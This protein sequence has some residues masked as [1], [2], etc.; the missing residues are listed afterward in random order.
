MVTGDRRGMIGCM[1]G[2]GIGAP[3]ARLDADAIERVCAQALDGWD[4]DGERVLVLVPD[5]TR[6]CPL[7]ELFGAVHRRLADRV[8]GI[9]VLIALGTHR[10]MADDA[11]R[12]HLGL[13]DAA[14]MAH[15]FPKVRLHNH[16]WQ[17]PG[18]LVEVGRLSTDDV[19][20]I[21]DGKLSLEVAVDI[22]RMAVEADR[23]LILGPVFPHEVAG[24]S[25]GN[26]YLF[27]GISGQRII[28]FFHWLGALI[29]NR[30]IIGVKHTPVRAVLDRCA[31]MVAADKRALCMV[32][33][34]GDGTLAGLY[35]GTPETAWSQ[36][37]DL[38][39]E[40]HV[41]WCERPFHTVL[42][43]LPEMY[44]DVWTAGKGMYKVE[45]V[46]ADGGEVIL[47]APHVTEVSS[48]H[49]HVLER[50]GYHVRDWFVAQW[51][52]YRDE[53]WGV[54]AH[55]THVRGDGSVTVGADGQVVER[56]RVAVTLAT[57]I[58]PETCARIGLG[59]RDP[60][61]IDPAEFVD[62]EADGVLYVPRAGELLFR[63][64]S[65]RSF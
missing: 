52:R 24:Y 14:T 59:Y 17:D 44:A 45:P 49:G 37:A 9:D 16:A 7:A 11:M 55:S 39:A 48:V 47:W 60:A 58:P 57:G 65:D 4:V 36:A 20:A 27:P 56:P 38:S 5:G 26:K 35:H 30:G 42:S 25:G 2:S 46:V 13:G 34:P 62:R 19:E 3:D 61:T 8:A 43:R 33:R 1:V 12:R 21:S 31:A 10:P 22:N 29:T 18:V 64:E 23:I 15:D 50:I 32:V 63:L 53:P 54:L 40:L 6:T 51:E 41:R 28:D